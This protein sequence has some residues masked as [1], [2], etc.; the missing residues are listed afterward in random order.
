LGMFIAEVVLSI[1]TWVVWHCSKRVGAL[2]AVLQIGNVIEAVV[3]TTP[4]LRHL[5]V[6]PSPYLGYRGCFVSSAGRFPFSNFISLIVLE[7]VF[8]LLMCT[9]ALRAYKSGNSTRLQ[10]VIHRDG[11]IFYF[12]FLCTV[13]ANLIVLL[14][15]PADFTNLL[16]PFQGV[17]HSVLTTRIILNIRSYARQGARGEHL[18]EVDDDLDGIRFNRRTSGTQDQTELESDEDAQ[19]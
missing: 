9:S 19:L 7:F 17:V 16:I 13:I 5:K 6:A 1:R 10:N 12:Y 3:A 14:K 4:Y 2:L 11:I 18:T 8:L 15:L